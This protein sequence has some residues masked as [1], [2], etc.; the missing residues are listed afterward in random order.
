M[1]VD[2]KSIKVSGTYLKKSLAG[3]LTFF[4]ARPRKT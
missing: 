2:V 1:L 3:W 4:P